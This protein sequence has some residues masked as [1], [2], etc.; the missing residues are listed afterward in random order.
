MSEV[1][2]RHDVKPTTVHFFLRKKANVSGGFEQ[3]NNSNRKMTK[4]MIFI[5]FCDIY[6]HVYLKIALF[7]NICKYF[8]SG[9]G[10]SESSNKFRNRKLELKLW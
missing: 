1:N 3:R 4:N 9:T 8:L 7:S 2:A 10:H 5:N 6:V